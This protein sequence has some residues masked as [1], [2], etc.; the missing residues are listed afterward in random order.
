ML[1]APLDLFRKLE[2]ILTSKPTLLNLNEY[3]SLPNGEEAFTEADILNPKTS[4]CLAGWI[5]TLTP[6]AAKYEQMQVDV[7]EYAQ[8]ILRQSGRPQIP[9]A[10][11]FS[12]NESVMKL[13]RGRAAEE[14][15]RRTD[16]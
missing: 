4:H 7:V 13:I 11:F 5:V 14:R 9:T 16:G 10:F 3:H 6:N 2:E 8:R 1:K 12:D 15:A